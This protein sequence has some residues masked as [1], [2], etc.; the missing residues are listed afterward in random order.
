MGQDNGAGMITHLEKQQPNITS[1]LEGWM[2]NKW[3]A[4]DQP[5]YVSGVGDP[6]FNRYDMLLLL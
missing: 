1:C 2:G 6:N 4:P 5:N 3:W